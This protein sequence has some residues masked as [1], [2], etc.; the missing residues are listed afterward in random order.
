MKYE[1]EGIGGETDV[2]EFYR[3]VKYMANSI[4]DF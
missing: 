3:T 1:Q 2:A 4:L